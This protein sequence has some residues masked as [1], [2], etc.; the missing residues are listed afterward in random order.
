MAGLDT[1]NIT[2]TGLLNINKKVVNSR[3]FKSNL[4]TAVG[5]PTIIE[6]VASGF[7][8]ED[9]YVYSPLA[10]T[11]SEKISVNFK[12]IFFK[13]EGLQTAFQ[14]ISAAGA[15]L[16]MT[17]E[18]SR[19]NFT[20]RDLLVFSFGNLALE[21]SM[22]IQINLVLTSNSYEFT[23]MYGKQILQ[24]FG[25]LDLTIPLESFVSLN[26]GSS[27][28]NRENFW[29][30]NI[31]LK[32]F[33]IYNNGALLYAPSEG[34][35]WN[36][37]NILVSDGKI[38][39]IDST[40]PAANHIYSFPVT[41]IKRSGNTIL[42]TCE[43]DED[44][45]LVIREMGL[46]IQTASGKVLFGSISNLN[47][48]K[49]KG[50]AYDLV[51]TVDTTI[52]VVN[53]V[54]FPEEGGIVVEDPDFMEFKNFTT[55]QQVNTYVLTNLE[56]IIRMN[57]GAKGSYKNYSIENAQAGTGHN[58]P[59]VIYRLQ[60][61]IENAEDCYNSIDTFV[62]LTNKFQKIM[63]DQIDPQIIQVEGDLQ[64]PENGVI[65]GF[66]TSNYITHSSPFTSS[67]NWNFKCA[68]TSDEE[69]EGTVASLSNRSSNSPLEI[70]VL[71]DKCYLKVKSL[72][73]IY[74]TNLNSYY[75]RNNLS[76]NE[77]GGITYYA[78]NR[79]EETP[80]YNFHCNNLAPSASPVVVFPQVTPLILEHESISSS[81]FKLSVRT[82]ITNL[83]STQYIIG[84]TSLSSNEGFELFIENGRIKASFYEEGSG[85]LIG[86]I[87][88]RFNL[89]LNRFYNIEVEYDGSRYSLHYKIEP[90]GS[91]YAEEEVEYLISNKL[92]SLESSVN[93]VIGAQYSTSPQNPYQGS[94]DF[95][96]FSL[97]GSGYSWNGCSELGT[98]YTLTP[99]PDNTALTYDSDYYE[100][101]N[102]IAENYY[103][104]EIINTSSLFTVEDHTKYTVSISYSEDEETQ[105]GIYEVTRIINDDI[106]TETTVLSSIIPIVENLSNRMSLPTEVFVGVDSSPQISNPFSATINLVD[107][108]ISQGSSSWPFTKGVILNNTELIQYY[109]LPNLNK[110]QY[111]TKD[112]CNLGRKIKF[113]SDRFEGN[114]DII[115]FS[116]EEGI[117]LCMKV[118]LQDAEPKVLLYKSDLVEDIYFSLT[119]I[120]QTLT[121]TLATQD[122]YT[123]ISK[124]LVLQEYDAYTNEPI[125]VTVTFQ[126][127]YDNWGYLQMFKNNEAITE[128]K[129]LK[130]NPAADPSMFILSNYLTSSE[131]IG[132][133]LQ[134][135]VVIKGIISSQDLK[136]IN[137]LFDTNY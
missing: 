98:I 135:L 112:I 120:D 18:N 111:A 124:A 54:G 44:S 64:V 69:T 11:N 49:T 88:T 4:I 106:V 79:K 30:G 33:S 117:T 127:Q 86:T 89:K 78:W 3:A 26:L 113:L 55:I 90:E 2:N 107:W 119:F 39:L 131:H 104:G 9:Y 29:N 94:L 134:D 102:A 41:E 32:E 15:P 76:D 24:K 110:N 123:S 23:L 82:L 126:P 35:S 85:N 46:Y 21:D 43:I 13:K 40:T 87:S 50:L 115:D 6:G 20:Y 19:V 37:S 80:F 34:T 100:V 122:G 47:V 121:F 132:R 72:E 125:M 36:F 103:N 133:F 42:L 62:K 68:F 75:T 38:P 95:S 74:P 96:K 84:K 14:L 67:A 108:A 105:K 137:N 97:E 109:R 48:N 51:F 99:N 63:E 93:L 53:A 73:S 114:E 5:S 92:I 61:E 130:L 56:R 12:G 45:Y 136:Y 8:T 77:V 57:A 91:E 65:S 28:P 27:F 70:G 58:R 7:S 1:L 129:Y 16:I 71:N 118:A 60:Q 59:Q 116:Y 31:N 83:T 25:D 81:S 101:R 22:D 10:F 128:P 52:N 66:S 17:F